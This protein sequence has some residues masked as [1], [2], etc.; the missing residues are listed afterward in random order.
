MRGLALQRL[1]RRFAAIAV[2]NSALGGRKRLAL[3]VQAVDALAR[4]GANNTGLKTLAILLQAIAF[5]AVA[6]LEVAS[7]VLQLLL[8]GRRR[9]DLGLKCERVALESGFDGGLALGHVALCVQA[10]LTLA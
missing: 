2:G 8:A 6:A 3:E 4:G 9:R 1:G 7:W 10:A 5:L